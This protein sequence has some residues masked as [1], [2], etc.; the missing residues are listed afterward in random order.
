M[1]G[2]FVLSTAAVHLAIRLP[3]GHRVTQGLVLSEHGLQPRFHHYGKCR[4]L[5]ISQEQLTHLRFQTLHTNPGIK[6]NLI[7]VDVLQ[8]CIGME[9][10]IMIV[11]AGQEKLAS[12]QLY[13]YRAYLQLPNSIQLVTQVFCLLKGKELLNHH[14]KSFS[15]EKKKNW[16]I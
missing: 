2:H 10:I 7:Q 3:C 12:Q 8:I 6:V 5:Q 13:I 4:C 15:L 14:L 16:P 11:P 9:D 1:D